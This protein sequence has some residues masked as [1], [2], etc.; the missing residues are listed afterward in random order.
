HPNLPSLVSTA[1]AAYGSTVVS[2]TRWSVPMSDHLTRR[3]FVQTALLAAAVRTAAADDPKLPRLK[4]AVKYGMIRPGKTIREKFELIKSLGF[5]GVEVDSPSGL[6]REE[7]VKAQEST[8]I[9]IHG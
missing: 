9:K 6:D 4:K 7:A 8:G 5:Q 1:A 2:F 3:G